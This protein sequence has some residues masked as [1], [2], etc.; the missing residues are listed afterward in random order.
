MKKRVEADLISIAHRILKL[1]NKSEV[2]ILQIEIK[3]LYDAITILKF[4][5]DNFDQVKTTVLEEDLNNKL[6]HFLDIN[7]NSLNSEL[8]IDSNQVQD[9]LPEVLMKTLQL[10]ESETVEAP[11]VNQEKDASNF[12]PLFEMAAETLFEP[13][14]N[15]PIEISFEEL[16]G[17]NYDGADFVK[18]SELAQEK[19]QLL[20]EKA[21]HGLSISLNDRIG[22]EQ[23]LFAGSSEDF[24]RVLSQLN[25]FDTFEEAKDFIDEIVKPDYDNWANKDDFANRFMELVENKFK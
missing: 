11:I 1:K 17:K 2:D 15:S 4:Y 25:T 24:N 12:E 14:K 6:V 5:N 23:Q 9:E 20:F 10:P 7:A 3:K 21:T 8:E 18:P 22:F 13:I 16:V 19:K